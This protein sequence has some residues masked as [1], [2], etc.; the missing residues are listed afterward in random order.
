[1]TTTA[2]AAERSTLGRG[3]R[4]LWSATAFS[5]LADG[6]G[7]TAVP[8]IATTLTKDPLQ[9]SLV[10]ALA[11][12]PWLVFGLPA[13][14]IVD[15][16]DRRIVMAV[17]N[18]VRCAVALWLAVLVV[19]GGLSMVTLLIGVLLFGLGET[20]YDNATNAALTGVVERAQLDRANGWIQT[21]QITIDNF[22]A[23]PIGGVLFGVALAL[24]LWVG[25]A[26]YLIPIVLVLLLPLSAARPLREPGDAPL[27]TGVSA[28]E[29]VG[30]VWRHRYLRSMIGFTAITGSAFAFAQA[31]N[32]LFFLDTLHVKPA[33][34]GFLTA[35]IGAGALVGSLIASTL[36]RWFGRGPVMLAAN[37]V[38]GLGLLVTG[39]AP[40]LI[41]ALIAYAT[42][43][44]A[45]STWNVPWGALRQQIVPQRLFGRVLGISRTLTW[46][47]FPV[48]TVL[49]G[50]VARVSLPL[51][52]V[53]GGAVAM[54]A[55]LAGCRLL[56]VGTRRAGAEALTQPATT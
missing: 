35:V 13:G 4:T 8:L 44:L 25:S 56:V 41:T 2:P 42:A 20:L 19:T 51:P 55:A 18:G 34:I 40:N 50:L 52:F 37:L 11:F 17:A 6:I 22:I 14:M 28:R 29:A 15:R 27:E 45:V 24:P 16:Y 36:V 53:I 47:L 49:G 46:G 1:M 26:A 7:R 21:A 3:F 48:A 33:A 12:V 38:A 39:L 30:Y 54:V 31:A 32:F 10:T 5:G 43:A 23:V 9:I